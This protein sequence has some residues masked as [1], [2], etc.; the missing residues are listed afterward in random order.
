MLLP[1]F[2][3]LPF[4]E[5]KIIQFSEKPIPQGLKPAEKKYLLVRAHRG[6][7]QAA[8]PTPAAKH[9]FPQNRKAGWRQQSRDMRELQSL[10]RT[11]CGISW[12][13]PVVIRRAIAA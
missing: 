8:A 6:S 9:I 13:H 5:S 4:A 12:N 3:V 10:S 7:G 11:V 1:P 2:Q